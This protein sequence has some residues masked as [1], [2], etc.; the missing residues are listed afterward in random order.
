MQLR[1]VAVLEDQ[2]PLCDGDQSGDVG[3]EKMLADADANQ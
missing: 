2:E 1:D 3:S